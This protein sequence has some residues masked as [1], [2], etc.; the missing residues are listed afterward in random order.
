MFATPP[1]VLVSDALYAPADEA[2]THIAAATATSTASKR[3]LLNRLPSACP[4]VVH[5]AKSVSMFVPSSSSDG[6]W[7]MSFRPVADYPVLQ[8]E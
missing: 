5:G 3:L 4:P 1:V 2:R 7:A 8:F 6:S